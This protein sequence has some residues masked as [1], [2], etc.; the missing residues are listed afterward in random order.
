MFQGAAG[1]PGR[2]GI[3]GR[4]GKRVR[5]RIT[6]YKDNVIVYWAACVTRAYNEL[7]ASVRTQYGGLKRVLFP[8]CIIHPHRGLVWRSD[9]TDGSC[10]NRAV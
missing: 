4:R 2:P 8:E 6:A 3:P 7:W 10:C 1:M 5:I 9:I